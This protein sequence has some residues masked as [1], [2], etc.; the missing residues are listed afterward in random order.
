MDRVLDGVSSP[1]PPALMLAVDDSSADAIAL[2]AP[3]VQ[4]TSEDLLADWQRAGE[5]SRADVDRLAVKRQH[6]PEELVQILKFLRDSGVELQ[7]LPHEEELHECLL[8]VERAEMACDSL[9]MFIRDARAFPLLSAE[10]EYEFGNAIQLGKGAR[11]KLHGGN[12]CAPSDVQS[13]IARCEI[14]RTRMILSNLRL[15][16][17]TARRFQ[18]A[19]PS[20]PLADLIQ[21]GTFGLT[22]AVDRFDPVRGV[23]FATYAMWWIEQ[24]IRRALCNGASIIRLPV[25]RVQDVFSYKRMSTLLWQENGREP[26]ID[27]LA[28]A[29]QWKPEKVAYMQDLTHTRFVSI[30]ATRDDDEEQSLVSILPSAATS[31][32]E[33][34]IAH[35]RKDLVHVL[36]ER[37]SP[38]ERDI[39]RRRF[40]LN[41]SGKTET[42]EEIGQTYGLT[43]ERIRQIESTAL[44]HMAPLARRW[45]LRGMNE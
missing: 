31:P 4:K 15:V 13:V 35:E 1:H 25:H 24:T 45:R 42:L 44:D 14:A 20:F 26:A 39:V 11:E 28:E 18:F 36:V 29:L 32:Q 34:C 9:S 41:E 3:K 22:K 12:G 6:T 38:Q 43:R 2:L 19:A 40:G 37:L 21:E 30:E 16:V 27:E 23:R 5:L 17:Y 10:E 7:E 33:D 8:S